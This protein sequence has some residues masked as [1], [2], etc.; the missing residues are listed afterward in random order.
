MLTVSKITNPTY[1]TL[2]QSAEYYH[3]GK[4]PVRILGSAAR[5]LGVGGST[6][7]VGIANIF[8]GMS[9]DGKKHLTQN[10]QYKKVHKGCNK[11][12]QN[13]PGWDLTFSPPKEVSIAW[14]TGNKEQR[15]EI[16]KA[17]NEAVKKAISLIEKNDA[18]T[19]RGKG[20]SSR[21]RVKL[22]VATFMHPSSREGDVQLH[23][24]CTV[25]NLGLRQDGSTGTIVSKPFFS[26]QKYYG[27]I[28]R[29]ELANQLNKRLNIQISKSENGFTIPGIPKDLCKHFSKRSEQIKEQLKII[30]NYT[31]KDV[32][33]VTLQT[34]KAKQV[35]PELNVMLKQW[36]KEINDLGYSPEQIWNEIILTQKKAH[37]PV[38]L[39]PAIDLAKENIAIKR[40]EFL[41]REFIQETLDAT[42]DTG[43]K[44]ETVIQEAKKC[45]KDKRHFVKL[46][47]FININSS[48]VKEAVYVLKNVFDEME[49]IKRKIKKLKKD[50]SFVIEKSKVN[51]VIKYHRTSRTLVLV[52]VKH[53]GVQ[54]VTKKNAE[55]IQRIY[56]KNIR[57]Q[58]KV[59]LGPS[60]AA[61]LRYITQEPGRILVV[62]DWVYNQ[63]DLAIKIAAELWE[64]DGYTVLGCARSNKD[65][66]HLETQTGIPTISFAKLKHRIHPPLSFQLK[67]HIQGLGR[68][69]LSAPIKK[70]ES[71]PLKKAKILVVDRA[72]N[73]APDEIKM[74]V[75]EAEK[76][77]VKVVFLAT[78]V[79]VNKFWN[80]KKTASLLHECSNKAWHNKVKRWPEEVQFKEKNNK[81]LIQKY[82]AKEIYETMLGLEKRILVDTKKTKKDIR[83]Y[84]KIKD[85]EKEL[86][87]KLLLKYDSQLK[88]EIACVHVIKKKNKILLKKNVEFG[89]KV[90]LINDM[91]QEYQKLLKYKLSQ[92]IELPNE[93]RALLRYENM[94]KNEQ[95]SQREIQHNVIE[96]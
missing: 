50:K 24:H 57:K 59:I 87:Y 29:N 20:G 26:Q 90:S 72:N 17:I 64:K 14:V 46:P 70:M 23:V 5:H 48:K 84:E 37:K 30:D 22:V 92:G 19:R 55:K 3:D 11:K 89:Q 43:V 68:T 2:E 31:A 86:A 63:R 32:E 53:H 78:P 7:F 13:V 74:I 28:F 61:L 69:L 83:R 9:P 71:S 76:Q 88:K 34:R 79:H 60:A 27:A 33:R 36:Q 82:V 62:E 39:Q 73:L 67:W 4:W 75:E 21:E 49:R 12:R 1:Y 54:L 65:S 52:R 10:Q 42:V 81:N 16:E 96:R 45:L 8:K 93:Y 35:E 41:E 15:M 58:A 94:L 47:D 18:W 91:K 85:Y 56:R 38:L 95:V 51:R 6:N 25:F 40:S 44:V 80:S 77:R 66:I